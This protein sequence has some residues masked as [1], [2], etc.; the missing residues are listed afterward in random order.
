[1]PSTTPPWE[2]NVDGTFLTAGMIQC[3]SSSPLDS[4]HTPPLSRTITRSEW[5]AKY[6]GRLS[7]VVSIPRHS[8]RPDHQG[9]IRTLPTELGCFGDSVDVLNALLNAHSNLRSARKG[10]RVWT[11]GLPRPWCVPRGHD[12][13][14]CVHFAQ[15][16]LRRGGGGIRSEKTHTWRHPGSL[17]HWRAYEASF[18]RKRTRS[19]ISGNVRTQT[20]TQ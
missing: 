15:D 10:V 12:R 19:L 16:Q 7:C 9:V 1:M 3:F 5:V 2:P 8:A 4:S 11:R 17:V 18:G 13:S 6:I 20:S 14:R